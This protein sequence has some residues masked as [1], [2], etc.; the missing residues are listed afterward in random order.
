MLA[1]ELICW[2]SLHIFFF[3]AFSLWQCTVLTLSLLKMFHPILASLER[4]EPKNA[5]LN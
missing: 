5:Q 3:A 1:A 4:A 2:Q